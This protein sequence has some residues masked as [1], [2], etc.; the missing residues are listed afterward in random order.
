MQRAEARRVHK[1]KNRPLNFGQITTGAS[2]APQPPSLVLPLGENCTICHRS[3]IEVG[4][5]MGRRNT[6]LFQLSQQLA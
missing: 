3:E 1:V 6:N 5:V 4:M 2:T